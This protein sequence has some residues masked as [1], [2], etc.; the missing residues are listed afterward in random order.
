MAR[1]LHYSPTISRFVVS[2]LYHEAK[3]RGI[4]M[5]KL[6]DNLLRK[7]LSGTIGWETATSLQISKS[8]NQSSVNAKAA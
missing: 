3:Q 6:T 8:S 7:A 4:P 5:T 1:P 2:V